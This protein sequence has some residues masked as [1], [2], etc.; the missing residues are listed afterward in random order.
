MLANFLSLQIR[1]RDV[2]LTTSPPTRTRKPSRTLLFPGRFR[3]T[4]W[5]RH[6]LVR[7]ATSGVQ[8]SERRGRT[9]EITIWRK[10]AFTPR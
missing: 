4:A 10:S 3:G 1:I 5:L 9:T 7:P 8:V 2:G 6:W